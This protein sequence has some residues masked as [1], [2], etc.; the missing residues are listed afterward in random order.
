MRSYNRGPL[1]TR[2]RFRVIVLTLRLALFL[3][4][5]QRSWQNFREMRSRPYGKR[6]WVRRTWCLLF[7]WREFCHIGGSDCSGGDRRFIVYDEIHD[8]PEE[9]GVAI[10]SDA[11]EL[12]FDQVR[13]KE[14][15]VHEEECLRHWGC[16]QC[17]FSWWTKRWVRRDITVTN[18]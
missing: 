15:R 8:I 7:H 3:V 4:R 10:Q 11:P 12:F 9:A 14:V 13:V 6:L 1:T 5:V 18:E 16:Y 2:L 17:Q